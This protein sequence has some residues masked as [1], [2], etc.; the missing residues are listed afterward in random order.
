M[1]NIVAK[2]VPQWVLDVFN[3]VQ[4]DYVPAYTKSFQLTA[5]KMFISAKFAKTINVETR[6]V[7]TKIPQNFLNEISAIDF[8]KIPTRELESLKTALPKYI[9]ENFTKYL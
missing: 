4:W 3:R 6:Y 5:L 2:S 7:E 1:K 9:E 8:A